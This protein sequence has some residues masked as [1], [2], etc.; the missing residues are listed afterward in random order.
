MKKNILIF[1]SGSENAIEI[2]NSIKNS[3]HIN[4]YGASSKLDHSELI[5]DKPIISLP[6]LTNIEFIEEL[7][8]IIN[9]YKIDFIFPTHDTVANYLSENSKSINCKIITSDSNTNNIARHKKL[10]YELFE[11]EDFNCE[12]FEKDSVKKYPIIVKPNIG[13][14][15]KGVFLIKSDKELD[16]IDLENQLIVEYLPGKE[17]TVDCFT[18][19]DGKLLFA[20]GRIREEIKMGISFK[21]VLADDNT[22]KRVL[23]IAKIINSKLNFRGLWFFQVKED[24]NN[25]LKLL[26]ISTRTAGTM[27]YFRHLG[28][29]LP[30]LS[31]F[32]MMDMDVSIN[33]TNNY[34]AIL[35]RATQNRYKF[36][37]SYSHIYLDYDDT[38]IIN[39][40]VN[41][42]LIQFIYQAKNL[43]KKIVLL[44]KHTGCLDESLKHFHL[45]KSLFDEIHVLEQHEKKSSYIMS[46]DSIFIDN[47]YKERQ[48]V[49]KECGIPVFDVDFVKSLI[50]N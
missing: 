31:V 34:E 2:Y 17:Y 47:W 24:Q 13:E 30:L 27:G 39:N 1:P 7:N 16:V 33:L 28:V 29:N 26:E 5:Y 50:I 22:Q 11:D 10:T 19:K 45:S 8:N 14:G 23:E 12:I 21:A 42:E 25:D 35:F 36:S 6:Y 18:N 46:K 41:I 20:G 3:I 38:L 4:V 49:S 43:S 48:E 15:S 44:T 32:D 9:K 40:Q 37:F